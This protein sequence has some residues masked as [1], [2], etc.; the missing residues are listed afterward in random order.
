MEATGLL[1]PVD[2]WL[3]VQV[4]QSHCYPRVQSLDVIHQEAQAGH[5]AQA[6]TCCRIKTITKMNRQSLIFLIP[7]HH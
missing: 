7:R 3:W 5:Q 2:S 1:H 4:L 6:S